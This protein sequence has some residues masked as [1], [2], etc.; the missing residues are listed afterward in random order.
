M[1]KCAKKMRL[2][3][4]IE[5]IKHD[6]NSVV[7]IGTFDG[8]H[9]AHQR[10]IATTVK[11]AKERK[12]RSVVVTFEPHPREVLD[13]KTEMRLLTTLQERKEYCEQLGV[14]WLAVIEFNKNLSQ[15]TF[16]EFYLKYVVNGIGASAVVEGY[17]H[18]WGKNREGNIQALE[19]LG[20]KHGFDV[21]KIEQFN[22]NGVP[23][24]S[25]LIRKEIMNGF[26]DKASVL[27]GRPYSLS[28]KVIEGDKRGRT[29]G[30]PT[31]NVDI[32]ENKKVLPKD[33]IYFV[34]VQ[35]GNEKYFGM[36]SIGLRPTF[37]KKG[38]RIFEVNIL[39]FNKDIYGREIKINFLQ[40]LRDE[41]KFESEDKL[42]KKM[43]E[44][45]QISRE[46]LGK[47]LN[48]E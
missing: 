11:L 4:Y 42:V 37:Y 26:V 2:S 22:Y 21:V 39:D 6:K 12:G 34:Q 8:V 13:E 15:Q 10:I 27:L 3:P 32:T 28:G 44:D 1:I 24:S 5:N 45:E 38:K 7:T 20:I 40:R 48:K 43:H 23:V 36:S 25:S 29:L 47:Y 33:G 18:H 46:L 35:T 17:D 14:D 41:L 30:Y 31:A 9:L 19:K 16:D